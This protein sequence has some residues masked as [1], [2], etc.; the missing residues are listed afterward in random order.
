MTLYAHSVAGRPETEWE[1]LGVHLNAV[2]RTA[3]ENAEVFGAGPL[4]QIAGILHDLGKAKPPFQDKLRGRAIDAPHSGEGARF[5]A[6]AE[7]GPLG[8]ILAYAIAGHHAGLANGLNRSDARPPTPLRDRLQDAKQLGLPPGI[9]L[10]ALELP[11][12]L[13]GDVRPSDFTLQFFTRM[14]FSCLV[15]ADF[16]ETEKFYFPAADR[17]SEAT[18][19]WL[20]AALGRR[21]D[22]FAGAT[23]NVNALR[24]E[25]LV[26]AGTRASEAPGLFSLTVPTGGGKTLTSLRF[27]LDHALAH[28]LRRV[29]YVAPFT[30]IIEQTADVFRDALTDPDAVLEHHSGFDLDAIMDEDRAERMKLAAQNW[31]R[32]VVVTT[33][34]Q[35]FESL[36]A[37]R[38]Q[39][40]RKLHSIARSVIVLDEVQT[41]PVNLLRPCLAALNELAERYGCSVVFCTATQPALF[42]EDGMCVPEAPVKAREIAPD[43][44]R[45]YAAFRRVE[46]RQVGPLSN[47][48][49]AERVR[50]NKALV[51]VNNK[52]QAR[53]LF[54][55]LRGP[56]VYH[57]TTNMTA[58]HRRAVLKEVR[59]SEAPL[60]IATA[61]VEA[62]VDLDFPQVWRALAGIDS[63]AQAAG[64]CNRE[65]KMDGPGQVFVFDPENGF[66]PPPELK[67]NSD[68]AAH[69]LKDHDDP[70]SPEAIR[71]Y[72]K[73]LY[74]DRLDDLDAK[75]IMARIGQGGRGLDYDFADIARDFRLIE[76]FTQPLIVGT[77]AWGLDENARRQ[78]KHSTSAG[79]IARKVQRYTVPVSPRVRAELL[80]L[81][82]AS[83]IREAEFG[84]Q[85]A[86]LDNARLYDPEAGF[87]ADDVEDLGG[88]VM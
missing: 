87:G 43:P 86:V 37:N 39:K 80:R 54:D 40:C 84:D 20:R 25:I 82:A 13:I 50:G 60:L 42:R 22:R 12:P 26:A 21:L 38:T 4:A 76:E 1:E 29:I 55:L 11:T 48:A 67:Q 70:L 10:P 23:G 41:L 64:R 88:L 58:A 53:A 66:P 45:L 78:M 73:A 47:A 6:N 9:A 3:R 83:V 52:R 34:V 30:A 79:A 31:D 65:G 49:L 68:I 18:L 77:G 19:E 69:V 2:G 32:P 27:A 81:G 51:I 7:W 5:A 14:L 72:F 71:A 59:E 74:W 56:D 35:F 17:G 63:I 36:F 15:D 44:A 75:G 46:V 61:L 16:L 28:G 24:A 33:A 8:K 57:L 85:F 62:G